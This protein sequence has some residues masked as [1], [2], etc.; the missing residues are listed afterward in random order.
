MSPFAF[1]ASRTFLKRY[2]ESLPKRGRGESMRIAKALGVSTSLVSQ[3]LAGEKSFT[4]EQARSLVGYLGL[5]GPEADYLFFLICWERAG[6]PELRAFW[7]EKLEETKA[8]ALKVSSR[9]RPERRLGDHER[10]I[11]YSSPLYSLVRLYTSVGEEGKSL[12]EI[13]TRFGLSRA[14]ASEILRFLVD[15]GL[16]RS[17]GGRYFLGAQSTHAEQGSPHMLRHHS[18]W[19]VEAMHC[20]DELSAEELMYTAP[21]SLSQADFR[22]LREE[23]VQFVQKFLKR[24]HASPAEELAC[25]NLDFFWIRKR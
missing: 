22:A 15:T 8:L 23:M 11:F 14:R 21:V 7:K 6:S 9:L 5:S 17:E 4:A 12:S 25:L 2:L 24:V 18:N 3:V 20:A 10:T 19:R 1:E 16:C 13:S